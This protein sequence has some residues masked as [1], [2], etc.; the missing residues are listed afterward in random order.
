M[1]VATARNDQYKLL[2]MIIFLV[3]G[4]SVVLPQ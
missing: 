4:T 2:K 1:E 3:F